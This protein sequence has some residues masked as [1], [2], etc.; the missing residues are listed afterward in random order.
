MATLRRLRYEGSPAV[1]E[2]CVAG[3]WRHRKAMELTEGSLGVQKMQLEL[4][5]F[6]PFLDTGSPVALVGRNADMP[7]PT[8]ELSEAGDY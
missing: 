1:A 6:C 2:T 3:F 5:R 7:L 8:A 4:K